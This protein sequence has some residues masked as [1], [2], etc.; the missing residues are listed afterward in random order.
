MQVDDAV[1]ITTAY[2]GSHADDVLR[3]VVFDGLKISEL[4]LSRLLIG[5][6]VGGLHIEAM[7]IFAFT[8]EV[9]LSGF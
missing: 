6:D 9:D 4:P 1:L 2:Q 3:V 7:T 5:D 8:Y